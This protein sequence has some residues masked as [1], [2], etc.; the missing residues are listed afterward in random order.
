MD[1]LGR[2]MRIAIV[3]SLLVTTGCGQGYEGPPRGAVRGKVT[4]DGQVIEDGAIT[5]TPVDGGQGPTA[6][7]DIVDGIYDIPEPKGPIVGKNRVAI[8][9][10]IKTGKKVPAPP[11]AGPAGMMDEVV[12]SVPPHF[13]EHSTLIKDIVSGKNTIDFDLSTEE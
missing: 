1:R 4:L 5:F 3:A 13:N 10:P 2:V 6:G 12:E 8:S 11:V 7:G 9:A